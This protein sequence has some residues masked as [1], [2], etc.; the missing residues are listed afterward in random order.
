MHRTRHRVRTARLT[1]LGAC[2]LW[3]L[4]CAAPHRS[5]APTPSEEQAC[6]DCLARGGTWQPPSCTADC[7]IQDSSCFT[8]ACP[9]PCESG[10]CNCQ[11]RAD[12]EAVGCRW[13]VEH[14]AMWC[15]P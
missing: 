15:T 2:A 13:H 14:E 3:L 10:S 1:L 11:S 7:A 6:R 4:A 9:G 8:E 12:C 5:I